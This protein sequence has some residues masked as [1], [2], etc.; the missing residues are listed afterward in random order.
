[1]NQ[2][3]SPFQI[4]L[5]GLMVIAI[6]GGVIVFAINKNEDSE[7]NVPVE[8]W[9][10]LPQS[11]IENLGIKINASSES[12]IGVNI[13]YTE[14]PKDSF[15]KELIEALA[16]DSGPDIVILDDE[17]LLKHE[18]K[19]F[20]IDYQYYSQKQFKDNFIQA[21]ESLLRQNGFLGFPISVD[22]L[23]LYWNR[24]I[25]NNEG[26]TNPPKYW[27]DFLSLVP[28]IVQ[29]DSIGNIN[30]SAVAFGEYENVAN[31]KNILVTLIQQAGNDIV[32]RDLVENEYYV[33]LAD[34]FKF[35]LRPADTALNF[36]T[37][38]ANPTKDVYSW[39]K[40][41]PN[42]LDL[43]ISGDLAFYFGLASERQQ[44]LNKNPNLNFDVAIVPQSRSSNE[45]STIG[46]MKFVAVLNK[47]QKIS[48]A[49]STIVK[50]TNSI[51]IEALSNLLQIAPVRR[52]LSVNFT[53]SAYMDVF[54]KSALISKVF[55]DPNEQETNKIFKKMVE[56][57]MIG[58]QNVSDAVRRANDELKTL[59]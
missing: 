7:T 57:V 55:L 16:S 19:I 10:T 1:M 29:K 15:E 38:F 25:L 59:F 34:S 17:M 24:T 56:S 3:L 40:A 26:I 45:S 4:I 58:S 27:D 21:G 6:V 36:Y 35:T 51:G 41:M 2:K 5:L 50:V 52:D 31:A 46:K 37:Q 28:K 44:I 12:E 18:N 48:N 30:R 14:F 23:V 32:F 42:S 53:P 47:S 33:A 20:L 49:F 13:I 22:P 9:G 11:T 8:M 54:H 43:F 39:N